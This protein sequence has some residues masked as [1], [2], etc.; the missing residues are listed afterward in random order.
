M[1]HIFI[2]ARSYLF[3][4]VSQGHA[5][6]FKVHYESLKIAVPRERMRNSIQ[7]EYDKS[8]LL[9]NSGFLPKLFHFGVLSLFEHL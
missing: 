8:F 9:F 1:L 7:N 2:K 3:G 4:D 5:S 6:F